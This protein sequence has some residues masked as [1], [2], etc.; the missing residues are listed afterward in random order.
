M[1]I[2]GWTILIFDFILYHH[3]NHSTAPA[4]EVVLPKDRSDNYNVKIL[5]NFD[6]TALELLPPSAFSYIAMIDA[7]S[8]GCRV[9]VY[10]Y[11][12]VGSLN[13]T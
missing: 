2:L 6:D 5:P 7:G 11:G 10:R 4:H 8:S 9:H 13:G 1:A 3:S 12:K